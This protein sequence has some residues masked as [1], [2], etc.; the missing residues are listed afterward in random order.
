[1]VTYAKS[2]QWKKEDS[3]RLLGEKEKIKF[4]NLRFEG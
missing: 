4:I 2:Q 1:M 3:E